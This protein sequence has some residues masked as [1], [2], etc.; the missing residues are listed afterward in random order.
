MAVKPVKLAAIEPPGAPGQS[1]IVKVPVPTPV[2]KP[3]SNAAS[4]AE[5]IK[6]QTPAKSAAPTSPVWILPQ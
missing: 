3:A 6:E 1:V 4:P 2:Q 5:P